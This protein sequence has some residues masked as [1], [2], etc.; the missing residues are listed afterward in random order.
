MEA[1]Q[2]ELGRLCEQLF[3]GGRPE[4][5]PPTGPASRNGH[6]RRP[7]TDEEVI[8]KATGAK[9]GAEVRA[10]LAGDTSAYDKDHSRADMALCCHLAFWTRDAGQID[11]LFRSSKLMRPKW[12]EV[13]YLD[14]ETYGSHTIGEALGLVK[15]H[16]EPP[17]NVVTL[18]G[19]VPVGGGWA[20]G[21]KAG[22]P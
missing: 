5:S 9:N 8:A 20:K 4:A 16:Y 1:R 19:G 2:A 10:L 22:Q 14:G 21:D 3:P 15:E 17:L 11:R 12:D 18:K 7:L 13:H 6:A